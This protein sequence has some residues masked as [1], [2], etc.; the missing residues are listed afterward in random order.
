MLFEERIVGSIAISNI[1]R[2]PFQSC[3]LGYRMDGKLLNRGLMTEGLKAI[4][5]YRILGERK[6]ISHVIYAHSE[7][8]RLGYLSDDW[9]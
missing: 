6:S 8:A 3:Y 2:D 9:F 4:I 1:I 5:V 7:R